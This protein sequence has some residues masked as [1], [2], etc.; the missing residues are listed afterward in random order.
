[1]PL[2]DLIAERFNRRVRAVANPELTS[3]GTTASIL[4]NNNPNRVG[5]LVMN[6]SPNL[7]YVNI[8]HEVSSS[9]GI[10]LDANGGGFVGIWDE[11][12]TPVAWAWWIVAA[13]AGSNLFSLEIVEY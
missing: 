7:M 6:L 11:M 8:T 4:F 5:F 13:G 9:N 3:V 2:A 12:F 1:M 10:L